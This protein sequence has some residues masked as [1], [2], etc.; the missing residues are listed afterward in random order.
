MTD[1]EKKE[2]EDRNKYRAEELKRIE[3]RVLVDREKR[4]A[5]NKKAVNK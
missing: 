4:L 1:Q 3:Q 2:R 5:A